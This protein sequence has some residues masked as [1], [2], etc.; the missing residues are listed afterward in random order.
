MTLINF[1]V[2]LIACLCTQYLA[3]GP[4]NPHFYLSFGKQQ[5]LAS[6]S[7]HEPLTLPSDRMCQP[8]LLIQ[9]TPVS[10]NNLTKQI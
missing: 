10:W 4:K 8:N 5:G 9:V 7:A 1:R 2:K 6:E 3:N